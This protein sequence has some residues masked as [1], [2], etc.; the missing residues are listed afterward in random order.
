MNKIAAGLVIVSLLLSF[1]VVPV[2]AQEDFCFFEIGGLSTVRQP[3]NNISVPVAVAH[4]CEVLDSFVI[5]KTEI[6]NNDGVIIRSETV[7]QSLEAIGEIPEWMFTLSMQEIEADPALYIEYCEVMSNLAENG[8]FSEFTLDLSEITNDLVVGNNY[9]IQVKVTV[10]HNGDTVEL[11]KTHEFAYQP[12]LPSPHHSGGWYPGDAHIHS[13]YSGLESWRS[14]QSIAGDARGFGLDWIILTDHSYWLDSSGWEQERQECSEETTADF[15]CVCGEELSVYDGGFLD[16]SAHYLC[17]G[18]SEFIPN[19]GVNPYLLDFVPDTPTAQDAIANVNAQG[20]AG[21]IAHPHSS[22][23]SWDRW[24]LSGYTGLEVWNGP[25]DEYDQATLDSWVELLLEERHVTGMANSDWHSVTNG[26]VYEPTV[27]TYLYLSSL[28]ENDIIHALKNGHAIMTNGPLVTFDITNERGDKAIIGDSISGFALTLNMTW[29]STVGSGLSGIIRRISVFLGEVGENSEKEIYRVEPDTWQT[30]GTEAIDLSRMVP[31]ESDFYIRVE[32]SADYGEKR[33]YTNPIWVNHDLC[34]LEDFEWGSD[35]V[36]LENCQD[37]GSEVGWDVTKIGSSVV[38]IDE[39]NEEGQDNY[40]LG[41]KSGHWYRAGQYDGLAGYFHSPPLEYIGYYFM[42]GGTLTASTRHGDGSHIMEFRVTKDGHIEYEYAAGMHADTGNQ[43]LEKDRWYF[44]EARNIDWKEGTYDIY[45]NGT[46]VQPSAPM[47]AGSPCNRYVVFDVCESPGTG[48]VWIDDIRYTSARTAT[49]LE[50]N[51][52]SDYVDVRLSDTF[53]AFTIEFW[54]KT[55]D[56]TKAGTPISMSDYTQHNEILLYNYQNFALYVEG[57]S[58]GGTGVSANDG[59]WHHIAWTWRSSDGAT[60]L[61]KDGIQV[62]SGTLRAGGAPNPANLIVGQEQDSYGGGFQAEQAFLGVIDEIRIWDDVRTQTE[63]QD[64]MYSELTGGESG[65]VGYWNFNEGEGSVA[66]NFAEWYDGT[67]HGADWT[68]ALSTALKFNGRSSDYVDVPFSAVFSA[69]TIE[70]WM[71]TSDTTN[72]GTP[73]SCS[74]GTQHNEIILFNYKSF[75]LYIEGSCVSTGISAND[76]RWHHI[77]WT[78]RSSDGATKLFKDGIQ[79]Y[80]GTLRA[81]GAPNPAN[82]IVGQEQDSYGG[83][84]QAGQAFLGVIDE[85]RIWDDVRTQTEIQDNMY[86]ELRCGETGLVG[87][88]RFNE[89]EGAV[90][91][92]SAG[93]DHGTIPYSVIEDFSSI[94]DLSFY[95]MGY[96]TCPQGIL[97]FT[98][99]NSDPYYYKIGSLSI[100]CEVY[101][102]VKIRAKSAPGGGNVAQIYWINGPGWFTETKHKDFTITSDGAFHEYTIDLSGHPY[103][104]GTCTG[105]RHDPFIASGIAGQVDWITLYAGVN[106]IHC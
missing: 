1:T 4:T 94:S 63:I 19:T 77:A 28:T 5:L 67:I 73:I 76:G 18:I 49:A 21:F 71:K 53:S 105:F 36:C 25:W 86:S 104:Y 88:W 74:D 84:F 97:T 99:T 45:L 106:W 98:S 72:T 47:H 11:A 15:S 32:A 87:Y 57:S 82:L 10:L 60:K 58:T 102:V 30:W 64:N 103:W 38:E 37:Y 22:P 100:D 81:G 93:D 13:S 75:S 6:L 14:V 40:A 46:R 20:G 79:V 62:Y 41:A 54:M 34:T 56:T 26:G 92:D 68:R 51:G 35:G 61:L 27:W 24:D 42:T 31:Q 29:E 7:N 9:S 3:A 96:P 55:S 59:N 101:D 89:G 8:Y 52:S 90:V 43:P 83:G 17:Y 48:D 65:L 16:G 12:A 70:F 39:I 44:I 33:A 80:S 78:W 66:H 23:F 2:S 50:F 85:I 91:Y 69:F 95:G